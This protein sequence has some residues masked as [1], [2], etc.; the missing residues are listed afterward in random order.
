MKKRI[1]SMIAALLML[2]LVLSAYGCAASGTAAPS[3]S[4][5]TSSADGEEYV[6]SHDGHEPGES[7]K[8]KLK[9]DG[10]LR[11]YDAEHVE[12]F[13]GLVSIDHPTRIFEYF[14]GLQNIAW[15]ER[16]GEG[17]ITTFIEF[18]YVEDQTMDEFAYVKEHF[19]AYYETVEEVH[20]TIGGIDCVGYLRA[21]Y[22]DPEH[23]PPEHT[24]TIY[25]IEM[26]VGVMIINVGWM[27]QSKDEA[28]PIMEAMLE[29][30]E[31][32][33]ERTASVAS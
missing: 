10:E 18:T 7:F 21:G 9:V 3:A 4:D 30:V 33:L 26:P 2:A 13:D 14:E 16:T 27:E 24:S 15:H 32:D 17:Y 5:V 6:L 29:T 28:L 31:F 1:A 8:L 20:A 23:I 12:L 25:Y 22:C 11:T 19:E